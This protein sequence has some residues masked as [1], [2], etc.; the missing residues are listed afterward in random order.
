MVS[1]ALRDKIY[2]AFFVVPCTILILLTGLPVSSPAASLDFSPSEKTWIAAHPVI[3]FASDPNAPPL[4]WIDQDGKHQGI[5]AGLL[6]LVQKNTGLEFKLIACNNWQEALEKARTRQV[7]I[8]TAAA[9]TTDRSKFLLLTD[10]YLVV[11]GV[12]ITR[13]AV[14]RQLT[15][16]DLNKMKVAIIK[17]FAW[18][19]YL[20]ADYPEIRIDQVPDIS[21]GLRKVAMGLDDALVEILPSVLYHIEKDGISNLKVAGRANYYARICIAVRSDW[22]ELHSIIQKALKAI[23]PEQ[24]EAIVG[25]WVRLERQSLF[26]QKM[27]WLIFL[28][29][30]GTCSLTLLIT[31]VWNRSLKR[32]VRLKTEQ[33]QKELA[34][35]KR[36]QRRL[37]QNEIFLNSVFNSIQGG[38]SVLD[39]EFN[40]KSVNWIMNKWCR[41]NLP[42]EGKKCYQVFRL[43]DK[44]C[45]PCPTLRCIKSGKAESEIIQGLA[46]SGLEWI[47]LFSYPMLVAQTGEVQGVVMFLRDIT[48][49]KQST[50]RLLES[51]AKVQIITEC[52]RDAIVMMNSDGTI[53]FWNPAAERIFG[54]SRQEVMGKNLHQTLASPIHHA[55]YKAVFDVFRQTGKGAVI[56]RTIELWARHK[57]GYDF[58]VE[59][60]LSAMKIAKGWHAVAIIRDIR[61]RKQAEAEHEKLQYQLIQAQKMES[62]GRLAGGVAHD[63]NNMLSVIIGNAELALG[64]V[65]PGDKLQTRLE[66]I[67]KAAGRSRA[68]T[69]QLL[70]FARQQTIEPRVLDLNTTVESMLKML[71][72]LIGEDINLAWRPGN[73]LWPIKIDPS[74]VDQVLA[75]LC[76]NARDAISGVGKIVIETRNVIFDQQYCKDHPGF[77]TGQ[78][79]MLAV[80]DDGRGLDRETIKYIFEP[81]FTTKGQSHGTGLGLSMVYGI[82]KQNKGFINVYSEPGQGSTFK[83]YLPRHVGE[84]EP[85]PGESDKQMPRGKGETVLIVEDEELVLKMGQ[86]MLEKLGY[87]VFVAGTPDLALELAQKQAHQIDILITDV[88]MPGMNGRQLAERLQELNPE[89]KILFMSG[90]TADVIVHRGVLEKGVN[91]IQK[92][93]SIYELAK[94]VRKALGGKSG[95]A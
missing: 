82:V 39:T 80:S 3:C 84:A 2:R 72:R 90:Y 22:P 4:E 16:A 31:F 34:E 59:L 56:G 8:L 62:V 33:L 77:T 35:R 32:Q 66:E 7:D 74:Q 9:P 38:I 47:E 86:E 21:T 55:D 15:L 42:L 67:L 19:D 75:N 60:S 10:P 43:R 93:F 52:A 89:V 85:V 58:P 88:I 79:V 48:E 12:I 68:I 76:V 36:T 65:S 53:S 87:Q 24:K 73:D 51:E 37:E 92:P 44:P 95:L 26:G 91:L 49:I 46:G 61:Q 18:E 29:G 54:Y 81:F 64:D 63:F 14:N 40:I 57:D 94:A 23:A 41:D 25:R 30:V 83:I 70:A 69:R 11:P 5:A 71:H 45:N 27:F 50:A 1:F 6:K 78:F 28:G 20:G 17:G 13:T